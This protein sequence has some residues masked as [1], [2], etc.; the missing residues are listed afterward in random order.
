VNWFE[1]S[2]S[3]LFALFPRFV[4]LRDRILY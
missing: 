1:N 3:S 4:K 2:K